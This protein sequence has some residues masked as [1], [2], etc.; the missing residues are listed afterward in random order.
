MEKGFGL[1]MR[2]WEDMDTD[3]LVKIFQSFDILTSGLAHVCRGWRF[4]VCDRIF[5][6]KLDLSMIKS[7]FI[8]IPK[9][10]YVYVDARSDKTL[11]RLLK[12]SLNLSK[13]CIL[14]LIFHFNLYISDE[15]L[16]Y[17][18]ERTQNLKCLVMPAWNRIRKTG[19][20]KAID[21]WQNLESLT[22]PSI[23]DPPY[24][25][26]QIS[27][28]CKNFAQLKVMGPFNILFAS[29]LT[30]FLPDL[31]ILSIRCT[32]IWRDALI[33]ILD[34]MKNLE[35]LN[36]SHCQIQILEKPKTFAEKL[37]ADIMEKA[38]FLKKLLFCMEDSCVMCQ[39]AKRDEGHMRWYKYEEGLWK[40]D[41]VKAL[42]I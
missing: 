35:V 40:A 17:T 10:P 3:I 29:T 16:I 24:L 19:M 31:K 6:E 37:D 30:T 18:A 36:I 13:G 21:T 25:L 32:T 27:K 41:E 14:T 1:N 8:I 5:G 11:M 12:I 9:R 39:R 7:N 42:A 38:A 2:R 33:M 23:S 15:Q 26:E 34:R 4:V 20:L 22:M 28:S